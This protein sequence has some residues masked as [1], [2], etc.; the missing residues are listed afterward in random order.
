MDGNLPSAA[1]PA[2][3]TGD[4]ALLD[5]Y[6]LAVSSA[7][8]RVAPAVV[9]LEVRS[10]QRA[11][12]RGTGSAFFFTPD[13]LLLTNSH[14]VHAA[15]DIQVTNQEGEH[16]HADILG[17]DPDSDLA[18]IRVSAA[19]APHVRFA[20]SAELKIGQ[21][22]IAIGNPLGFE[23]SVTAGVV[24]AVGRSLRASTGRLIDDVIQTDAALNPGN[25]GGPL[26]DAR[27][28]VIGVNTAIIPGAQ[29]LCFATASDTAQWV[30]G[31]LLQHGRVRRA[32]IG[33]AGVNAPVSRRAARFHDLSVSS[34]VRV[35]SVEPGSPAARAG[36]ESGDL[37]VR[38][39]E[40]PVGGIDQLQ[41]LLDEQRLNRSS[42]L[43]VLRLT[44]KLTVDVVPSERPGS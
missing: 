33:I 10:G 4:D 27:G 9:H 30:L 23:H 39:D 5:A 7:V 44:R 8:E 20:R 12:A 13:G 15:S 29:G 25:S 11:R 26:I 6:S 14:V 37:I 18:V 31:A 32:W 40:H 28:R 35:R 42:R 3:D 38:L 36:I 34:G 2:G 21:I 43:T 19:H 41:R 1:L 22:A 17:D 16:W 24:S